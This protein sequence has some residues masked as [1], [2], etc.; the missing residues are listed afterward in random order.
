MTGK[1]IDES[2]VLLALTESESDTLEPELK[3]WIGV[4]KKKV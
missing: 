2:T 1:D 4:K 3:K